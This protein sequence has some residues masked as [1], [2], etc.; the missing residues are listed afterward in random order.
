MLNKYFVHSLQHEQLLR[1]RCHVSSCQQDFETFMYCASSRF[2][3]RCTDIVIHVADV[4]VRR[5]W[6][7]VNL[8]VGGECDVLASLRQPH[9]QSVEYDA[10]TVNVIT[11]AKDSRPTRATIVLWLLLRRA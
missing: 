11:G 9:Y 10:L 8:V 7:L 6:N 2:K 5:I 4:G 3:Q 1:L